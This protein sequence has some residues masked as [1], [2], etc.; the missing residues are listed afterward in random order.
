MR[1]DW[2]TP[3]Q[4]IDPPDY[5]LKWD[6]GS[7]ISEQEQREADAYQRELRR[8]MLSNKPKIVFV[9]LHGKEIFPPQYTEPDL[10]GIAMPDVNG[11][12]KTKQVIDYNAVNE[13]EDS[14]W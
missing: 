14:P 8:R 12:L 6:D 7:V 3:D 1:P 2:M 13:L 11:Q 4:P 5:Y 9:D 10:T